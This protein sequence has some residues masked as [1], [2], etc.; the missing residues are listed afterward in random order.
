MSFCDARSWWMALLALGS[1]AATAEPYSFEATYTGEFW[2]V[3]D[4]PIED[5]RYVDQLSLATTLDLEPMAGLP[6]QVFG[7]VLY[8]NRTTLSEDLIGDLHVVSSID[9]PGE[10]RLFELWYQWQSAAEAWSMLLGLYDL[11][12]EFDVSDTGSL[13]VNGAHGIGTDIGQTGENGPSIYPVSGLTARTAFTR[14]DWTFRA[15]LI[16]GVPGNPDSPRSNRV[17]LGNGDGT[18]LVTEA[19]WDPG[20]SIHAHVGWWRYSGDFEL[21]DR[22][23]TGES[24]GWYILGERKDL[25]LGRL[26]LSVFGRFGKTEGDV[27]P[28]DT[29]VG[30]GVVIDGLIE[31]RP[32]DQLGFA[33]AHGGTSGAYRNLSRQIGAGAAS[34]ETN[35]EI[36]YRAVINDWLAL[37]PDVQY[38]KNPGGVGNSD[39][40]LVFGLRFELTGSW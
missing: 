8:N 38:V 4:G 39:D 28:L 1:A 33:V 32:E 3:L 17:R 9:G 37:Q 35:L 7:H 23:G 30:A 19:A 12:S 26:G 29:Y 34:S 16:D 21:L 22:P 11:N 14:S 13:F 15:A 5:N 2:R 31:A 20:P 18:L 6:G 10:W 27:V 40:A 36:T 25:S 24:H